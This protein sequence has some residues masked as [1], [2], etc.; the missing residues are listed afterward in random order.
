MIEHYKTHLVEGPQGQLLGVL[1]HIEAPCKGSWVSVVGPG[2][3]DKEWLQDV[4]GV[5][6]DFLRSSLDDEE[7][8]RVEY[9]EDTRQTLVIIDCPFVEEEAEAVDQSIVQYDTH[10][11]AVLFLPEQDV[12]VTVTLRPNDAVQA[13]TQ[14]RIREVNTAQ[15]SRFLL[16]V[17]LYVSQRYQTDLRSISRQFRENERRLRRSMR[18]ADLVKMLGF[19]KSLVYFESSLKQFSVLLERIRYGRAIRMYEDDRDLLEDVMVEVRQAREM[20]EID[21]EVL[22]QTMDTFSTIIN[23]NM[24]DT[25]HMLAIITLVLSVPT[26][27][28]GF[29]GMNTPLPADKTWWVPLILSVF[30][31]ALS[32]VWLTHIHSHPR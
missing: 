29:Y 30:L 28:Y 9:D 21:T 18:S 15:R 7:T 2:P 22:N 6:E 19:E 12:I 27:V 13:V 24:N 8:A 32:Y 20:C 26:M 25:M 4:L 16:Q 23:N 5:S 31:S 17:L 14:G 10:P 11:L 3:Q 1:D